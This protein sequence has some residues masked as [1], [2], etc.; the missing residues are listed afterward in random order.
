MKRRA[1]GWMLA[2][3]MVLALWSPALLQRTAAAESV[4]FTVVNE[5]VCPLN[6]DTMPFWSGGSLYV[7]STVLSGYDLGLSYMRD[8][9]A[10]KATLYNSRKVL[11]FDLAAGGANNKLG[12]YYSASAVTRHGYVCFPVAFVCS[13]FSLSYSLVDTAWAPMVRLRSDSA[14]LSDSQFIDAASSMLSSRYNAY[15]QGKKSGSTAGSTVTKP[16]SNPSSD[17]KTETPEK[18]NETK[19]GARVL[20]AVRV[21]D[22]GNVSSM[23]DTLDR[24]GCKA[25]FFF[26]TDALEGQDDLLR[27]I[28]ASGHRLGLIQSGGTD[29]LNAANDVL[30]R[31]TGTVSRMVLSG[32]GDSSARAAG[33]C[34]YT[35]TLDAEKLGTTA[36]SR[37]SRIKTKTE[38]SGAAVRVL[39]GGDS[40][41]AAALGSVCADWKQSGCTVRA[42]NETACA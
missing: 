42:V 24:Y 30:R 35:P 13:Y 37:A 6:D 9:S 18:D 26:S 20:L 10:Q 1:A 33:Y 4:Y 40:V 28:V 5:N 11:E 36:S 29:A 8:T 19:S 38:K 17:T 12:T 32:A 23:L 41:S 39:L 7:P 2:L 16:D 15:E 3:A 14:V 21:D 31:S 22:A 25:A 27:R 34:V